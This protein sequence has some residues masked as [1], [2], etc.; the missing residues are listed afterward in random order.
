MEPALI[1]FGSTLFWVLSAI[2]FIALVA[3]V[4]YDNGWFASVITAAALLTLWLGVEINIF[5]WV[6]DNPFTA[7]EY[8]VVYFIAG[9]AWAITKW[10]FYCHKLLDVVKDIKVEFLN[11]LSIG[12]DAIPDNQRDKFEQKVVCNP[13][14]RNRYF[15]P[16]A[17]DHKSDW[18]MW[19]TWWP[20][21]AFWTILNQP[22]KNIWLFI[23]S[24]LGGLMQ[25]ISNHVF[26][27][28]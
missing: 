17:M 3:S 14:Y 26:R 22:I 6:W 11:N 19:A 12:G 5:M 16:Q 20:V 28:I 4:E 25:K 15:P 8:F 21:S 7:F 10:W 18:L 23:Y 1:V 2:V 13:Y 9:T 24:R 27:G